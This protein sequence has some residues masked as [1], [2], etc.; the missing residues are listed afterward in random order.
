M[1]RAQEQRQAAALD[2]WRW[3]AP[4]FAF[5][6]DAAWGLDPSVLRSLFHVAA[7]APGERSD[8]ACRQAVSALSTAE[9]FSS[10]VHPDTVQLVQLETI[11]GLLTF[12]ESADSSYA[13][14]RVSETSTRLAS[15]LDGLIE[16]SLHSHP[17]EE[18]HRAYLAA[19]ADGPNDVG[20][21]AARHA[22]VESARLGA[23]R[24]LPPDA[25]LLDSAAGRAL[26]AQ[27]E[28]FGAEAVTTLRWLRETGY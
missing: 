27:C 3:R 8:G 23:L 4:L 9:L 11:A 17:S 19:R 5:E 25:G 10:E 24:L 7:Q 20:Y 1:T 22:A 26:L 15:Y 21:F 13:A 14:A 12:A 6:T 18:A 16:D 2:L 28:E